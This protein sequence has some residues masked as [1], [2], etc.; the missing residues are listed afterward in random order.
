MIP[1]A[2]VVLIILWIMLVCLV[3]RQHNNNKRCCPKWRGL[4]YMCC[5][6]LILMSVL[7]NGIL[8][9]HYITESM[10]S[11]D[12]SGYLALTAL[13]HILPSGSL[14]DHPRSIQKI[15]HVILYMFGA[16]GLNIVTPLTLASE[17]I[18]KA[19]TGE[20]TLPEM[21]IVILPFECLFVLGWLALQI[22]SSWMRMRGRIKRNFE[23]EE[24]A[25]AQAGEGG[26]EMEVRASLTKTKF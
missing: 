8:C 9:L 11:K 26:E 16:S 1:L 15:P 3:R 14:F 13:L 25:E 19:G 20:R 23:D 22:Y 10:T 2:A 21:H 17:L 7:A 18:L 6:V 12:Y 5:A 4:G 24:E